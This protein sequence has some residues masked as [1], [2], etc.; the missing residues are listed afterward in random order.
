[1]EEHHSG[2]TSSTD[3]TDE[4]SPYLVQSKQL[5]SKF[6]LQVRNRSRDRFG[7]LPSN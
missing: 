7:I 5:E 2:A 4:L 1:M 3:A 6:V